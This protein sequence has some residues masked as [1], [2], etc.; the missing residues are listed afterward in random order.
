MAS[1]LRSS[2]LPGS[3]LPSAALA[4]VEVDL[5]ALRRNV[6]R[7]RALA[8]PARFAAVVKANAYG[9]G[10]QRVA[11]ALSGVVDLLCVYRVEEGYAIRA[12]GVDAP[13]LV[14]GP[15]P[16][17]ELG[18]AHAARL[19]VT[20]W[21]TGA[22]RDDAVRAARA[23][24]TAL[25]VHAKVDTGVTR[26]GLSAQNAAL[27]IS[28]YLDDPALELQGVFTHLAAVE[29]LESAFTLDQ[30][31]R[32]GSALRPV[33]AALRR[34]GTLRHAAASAAA[35]LFPR[36]R[37]DLVRV[38]IAAY[39]LWPSPQTRAALAQ[40][41]DL[42]PALRWRSCLVAVR[43]VPAE[44]SIGYGCSYRTTAAARIGV[45]PIGYA[46]GIP[47]AA[48]NRGA[49]L[50]AGVR[51]PI[52]G[53]VCMNMTLVDVTHVP[54]AHAGATVTLIG[55]DGTQTLDAEDWARWADTICYEIVARLPAELPRVYSE[56]T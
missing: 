24:G 1:P 41:I 36:L 15:V 18:A 55:R 47:R 45:V 52:V 19:A 43:D 31:D 16:P 12:A 4:H 27:A 21:D 40:P 32:F 10:L 13:V 51:A 29:E 44:T 38:G 9:H 46:E 8:A 50:V 34:R 17:T 42:E 6:A 25:Q 22:Y 5:G 11:Q 53:R 3:D 37:L 20:L 49:M 48:S 2:S 14:L 23:A 39:G 35:M 30:L 26:L 54:L 7:L 56:G 28:G 33:D